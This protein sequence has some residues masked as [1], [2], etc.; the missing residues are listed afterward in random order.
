MKFNRPEQNGLI[1]VKL[2]YVW[3]FCFLATQITV[4]FK[5]IILYIHF[6]L[7]CIFDFAWVIQNLREI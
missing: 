4:F 1:T 7:F 6:P 3:S 2:S 5:K